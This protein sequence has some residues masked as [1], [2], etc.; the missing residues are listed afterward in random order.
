M[1]RSA[2]LSPDGTTL[3][4][5]VDGTATEYLIEP[6][7]PDPAIGHP[8]LRLLKIGSGSEFAVYDLIRT[9]H[10]WTCSCGDFTFRHQNDGKLCKHLGAV[11]AVR[12]L[13]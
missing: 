6:L 5:S 2:K 8:A 4:I 9:R 12:L 1:R 7:D 13:K 11:L 10:G 3:S